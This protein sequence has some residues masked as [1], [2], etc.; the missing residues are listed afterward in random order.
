MVDEPEQRA[1]IH[2]SLRPVFDGAR[3]RPGGDDD[4]GG[5]EP[6]GR[7]RGRPR[8]PYVEADEAET[9]TIREMLDARGLVGAHA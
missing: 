2:A 3:R 9:Q 7:P 4:Q 1:A 5:P 8:L 6:H